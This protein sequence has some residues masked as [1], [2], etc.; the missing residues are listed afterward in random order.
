MRCGTGLH[1]DDA[2]ASDHVRPS[3]RSAGDVRRA[4]RKRPLSIAARL[5][6]PVRI[7]GVP[8]CMTRNALVGRTV[9]RR[10]L[11]RP[12]VPVPDSAGPRPDCFPH[13]RLVPTKARRHSSYLP[14]WRAVAL[15]LRDFATGPVKL[16]LYTHTLPH[17]AM[18]RHSEC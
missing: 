3:T 17:Q 12:S 9:S 15:V 10:W 7:A 1:S 16:V 13:G 11:K 6:C 4:R 5:D 14:S 18:S 2:T 8:S